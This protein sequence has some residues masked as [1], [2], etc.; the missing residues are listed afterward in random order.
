MVYLSIFEYH[1]ISSTDTY[2]PV[3]IAAKRIAIAIDNQLATQ[4]Q[5]RA[6]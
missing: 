6:A 5:R 4:R 2:A 3:A 1:G